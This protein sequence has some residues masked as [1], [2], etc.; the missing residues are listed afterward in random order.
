MQKV[1][2]RMHIESVHTNIWREWFG[3]QAY[4]EQRKTSRYRSYKHDSK[5]R[6]LDTATKCLVCAYKFR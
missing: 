3:V 6:P 1:D 5:F 4:L 2:S